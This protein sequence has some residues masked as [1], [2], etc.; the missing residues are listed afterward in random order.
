VIF[1]RIPAEARRRDSW[2]SWLARA[3]QHYSRGDLGGTLSALAHASVYAHTPQQHA[4]VTHRMT[5]VLLEKI[6]TCK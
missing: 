4:W 3:E 5:A 6:G 1:T 2:K